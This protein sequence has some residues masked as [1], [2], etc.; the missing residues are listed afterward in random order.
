MTAIPSDSEIASAV[1]S[2]FFAT[3]NCERINRWNALVPTDNQ[4]PVLPPQGQK[5]VSNVPLREAEE[6]FAFIHDIDA[7]LHHLSSTEGR[8]RMMLVGYCHI[9]ESELIPSL[10]WNQLRLLHCLEPSWRFTRTTKK[11]E[12][13]ACW[14]PKDKYAEI[15]RLA[16][17]L[18]QPIGNIV[19]AVWNGS[20]RNDF[21][22][23]RYFLSGTYVL[24]SGGLSPISRSGAFRTGRSFPFDEVGERYRA[25]KA[26]MSGVAKEH[27]NA[28]KNYK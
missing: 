5:H 24:G 19:L 15:N 3:A 8:I 21:N 1:E 2:L 23:S 18:S 7:L 13:R 28:C 26:L 17:P 4:V 6:T 22:H 16:Q 9:M 20:L 10:I 25:A 11:G 14:L 12:T 27:A